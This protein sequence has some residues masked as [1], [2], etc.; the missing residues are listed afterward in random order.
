M[1]RNRH[2]LV[3]WTL[4]GGV[5]ISFALLVLG[6]LESMIRPAGSGKPGIEDIPAGLLDGE[7]AATVTAGLVVLMLTPLL[8]VVMLTIEFI[9]ERDSPFAM[10]SIGVLFLLA[11]TIAISFG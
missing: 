2:P 3:S 9:R 7:P 10:I 1:N 6:L 5:I 8:R 4:N 11:V